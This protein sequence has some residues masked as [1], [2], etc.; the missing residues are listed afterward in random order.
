MSSRQRNT[1][2]M[3]GG[4]GLF[5]SGVVVILEAIRL[6]IGTPISPQPGFFPF[7]AGFMIL[8]LAFI[9]MVLAWQGRGQRSEDLGEV[10]RPAL[11][12]VGIGVYVLFLDP[13]GYVVATIPIAALV[14]WILGVRSWR[15]IIFFG[16]GLSIGTY[17]LFAVFLGIELPPGLLRLL[18]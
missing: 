10:R 12:V 3:V 17:L 5:L 11:L 8:G 9:L 15:V 6:R 2:D 13:L 7:L 18:G 16:A 14:L 1:G 4:A